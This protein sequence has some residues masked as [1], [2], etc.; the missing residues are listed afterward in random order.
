MNLIVWLEIDFSQPAKAEVSDWL[1]YMVEKFAT[2]KK[3]K[4]KHGSSLMFCDLCRSLRN[5]TYFDFQIDYCSR[6]FY[7]NRQLIFWAFEGAYIICKTKAASIAYFGIDPFLFNWMIVWS[8]LQFL[9][10]NHGN[11]TSWLFNFS[12]AGPVCWF[13]T[14]TD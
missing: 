2:I 11:F 1:C 7:H 3:P 5:L 13:W 9:L 10:W 6:P 4:L 8:R 12:S 14:S